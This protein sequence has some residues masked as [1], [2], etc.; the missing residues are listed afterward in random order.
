VQLKERVQVVPV[1]TADILEQLPLQDRRS[2]I[3]V[4]EV[5]SGINKVLDADQPPLAIQGF[6]DQGLRVRDINLSAGE[7]GEVYV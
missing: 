1:R 5:C 7:K 2:A 6:I 3:V 4:R